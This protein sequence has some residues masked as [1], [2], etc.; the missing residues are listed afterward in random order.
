MIARLKRVF[1]FVAQTHQK[2][3][4]KGLIFS[5]MAFC[6]QGSPLT[7]YHFWQFFHPAKRYHP[8]PWKV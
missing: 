5:M 1:L 6:G 7:V 3:A 8:T 4:I 2:Q